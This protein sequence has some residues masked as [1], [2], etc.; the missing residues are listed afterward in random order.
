MISLRKAQA[1]GHAQHGW[2]ESYHSFSFAEYDEPAHRH[3]S[4]LRVINEDVIA[5]ATGFGMHAH[6]DME[7]ITYLLSGQIRH[8]DSMGNGAMIA[9]G[10]VQHM[11]A[12]TGV[13]HSEMNASSDTAAHLL[14]IWLLP[15]TQGLPPSYKDR[16][17]PHVAKLNRWCLIASPD[18]RDDSFLM[19]QDVAMW[20]TV[21]ESQSALD[22]RLHETRCAYLHVARGQ[23]VFNGIE[24]NTGDAAKI[25]SEQIILLQGKTSAEVL[26]FDL[27]ALTG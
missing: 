18:G 12:G 4:V 24:L 8:H 19:H 26:L 22:Y 23:V 16:H 6:R 14:Q 10:D 5:P 13:R 25:E 2:L 7:I 9:S 15:A 20:A 17:I 27:P 11:S 1:R 3:Y 21:L